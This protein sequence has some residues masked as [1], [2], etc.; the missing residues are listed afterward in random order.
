ML[1]PSLRTSWSPPD[2]H[3]R[4]HFAPPATHRSPPSFQARLLGGGCLLPPRVRSVF[5]QGQPTLVD[6]GARLCLSPHAPAPTFHL[7]VPFHFFPRCVPLPAA[8]YRRQ[9]LGAGLVL[10][11]PCGELFIFN[12]CGR[13]TCVVAAVWERRCWAA[14]VAAGRRRWQPQRRRRWRWRHGQLAVRVMESNFWRQGGQGTRVGDG[15]GT[16]LEAEGGLVLG[17]GLR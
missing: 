6:R 13:H 12:C 14:A 1:W 7:S 3:H 9:S 17:G 8:A 11:V 10:S 5:C 15:G 16:M 4:S 2:A